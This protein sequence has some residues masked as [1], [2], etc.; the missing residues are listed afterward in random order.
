MRL[1]AGLVAASVA[2]GGLFVATGP[3]SATNIGN[4]GC[5]PGYW[6]THTSNWQEYTPTQTLNSVWSFPAQ[7]SSVGNMTF[8]QALQAQGGTGTVGAARILMRAAVA[9]FLNAAHEDVGYPYR[10]FGEPGNLYQQVQAALNSLN[11]NQMLNLA[12]KL[13]AANNLGCPL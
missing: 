9:A 1:R 11:R 4:E 5:T 2:A 10:R 3:A 7:L 8:L 12:A 6:K 13:D